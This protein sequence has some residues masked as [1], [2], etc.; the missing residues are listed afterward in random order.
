MQS[1]ERGERKGC[2]LVGSC[3]RKAADVHTAVISETESS[4]SLPLEGIIVHCRPKGPRRDD[5][6]LPLGG[7]FFLEFR[8]RFP[9]RDASPTEIASHGHGRSGIRSTNPPQQ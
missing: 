9:F 3:L 8:D 7:C 5:G 1:L 6:L 2:C 4:H